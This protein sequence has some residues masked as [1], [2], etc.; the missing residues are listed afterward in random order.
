MTRIPVDAAHVGAR[1]DRV[2]VDA[3]GLAM[4]VVRRLCADGRV[5]SDRGARLA[6]GDRVAS[7]DVVVV[8]AEAWLTPVDAPLA[9]LWHDDD[10]VIVDK[11]AGL[12][13][14]PVDPGEADSVVHRL[15]GSFPEIATASTTPR[16]GGLIHRLDTGTS[17]CLAAARHRAAWV[18]LRDGID[19]ARKTYLAVVAGDA[20]ALDG[21]VIRDPIAHDRQDRRRMITADDGQPCRTDVAVLG[22]GQG[23]DGV[24][25]LVRLELQGGRRH[26]L[27]VHLASRQHPLVGDALYGGPGGPWPMLHAWR[28]TLLG[29]STV[30]APL[31]ATFRNCLAA[32]AIP[33]PR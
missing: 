25:S 19:D 4:A 9:V 7:D 1:V 6:A 11:P 18:A 8:F 10:V 5:R 21:A 28:L 3:T 24:V 33:P 29:R 12:P 30:V 23:R 13:C 14:H 16:E 17:G 27:R 15:I 26:Q 32:A 31:P 20:A 2:V 22:V